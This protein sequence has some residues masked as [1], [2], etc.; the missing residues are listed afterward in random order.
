MP[1]PWVPKTVATSLFWQ[2]F[3]SVFFY[4]KQNDEITQEIINLQN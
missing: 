1:M 3:V 4:V 2:C